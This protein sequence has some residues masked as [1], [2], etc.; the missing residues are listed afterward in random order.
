MSFE[1]TFNDSPFLNN[2][3]TTF[4]SFNNF[5]KINTSVVATWSRILKKVKNSKLI[6]KSSRPRVTELLTEQ[7]KN[8]GVLNSVEFMTTITSFEDH[9]QLYKKIDIALDTFPYN[10]VTTSFEAIWMGV[11]VI[12]MKGY[13]FNS[14]CG[15]SINKNLNMEYLIAENE[16]DYVAKAKELSENKE[17][18]LDI[19]KKIFDQ[20][21]S[22]PLF[23]T[24]SFS[25]D[26]FKSLEKIYNKQ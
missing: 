1:R 25:N 11:P 23:D 14:R 4:G 16:M 7:F 17:K 26:F 10:G 15:E 5:G 24:K 2:N 3:L 21:V 13:N 12:T 8:Q 20:A 9:M 22:S 19:R 6:L 18:L